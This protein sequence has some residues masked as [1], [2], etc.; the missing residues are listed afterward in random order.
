M[1]RDC[2]RLSRGAPPQ[3][4]QAP[5]IPQGPQGSQVMEAAPVVSPPA[6]PARSGGQAGRGHP[7]GGGQPPFN[8]FSGRTDATSSD[9]VI[10]GIVPSSPLYV[11]MPVGDPIVVDRVYRL[12]LVVIGGFE[13]RVDQLLLKM[14]DYDVI[15]GMDWLSPYYAILD[16]YTKTM[17]MAM[18]GLPQLEWRGILDYIPSIVV[19]FLKAH[20]MVEKSCDAYLAFV[21]DVSADTSTVELVPV[22]RNFPDVFLADLPGM[23]PNRDI[24]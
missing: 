4:T 20:R 12:Y 15:S 7:R 23:P 19:S 2:P 10:I 21:R 22:V 11:S 9:A 3:T 6:R 8:A 1:V 13:T 17:I 5:R 14:I 18:H 24:A 16:Y